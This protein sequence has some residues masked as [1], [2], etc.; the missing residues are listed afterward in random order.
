MADAPDEE[1]VALG[2]FEA[3]DDLGTALFLLGHLFIRMR[4]DDM[5]LSASSTLV[6]LTDRG[7]QRITA[8]ARME[9]VTQP[10]MT[11]LVKRLERDRLVVRRPDPYDSRAVTVT[12]TAAGTRLV[13]ERRLD[14][15]RRLADLVSGLAEEDR[16]ALLDAQPALRRLAAHGLAQL[17]RPPAGRGPED[18]G[19]GPE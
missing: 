11:E 3:G 12:I 7:P 8:L 18:S 10:S 16:R 19:G 2:M 6:T 17:S 14:R 13:S 15:A 5:S 4:P 1:P 9:G